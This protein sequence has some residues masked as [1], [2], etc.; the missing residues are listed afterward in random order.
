MLLI[1]DITSS[2]YS[3]SQHIYF[4]HLKNYQEKSSI[5]EISK[6]HILSADRTYY[7]DD[8]FYKENEFWQ[9]IRCDHFV[10]NQS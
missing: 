10:D 3:D 1:A 6:E 7:G 5:K 9:S 8:R 2:F 4:I